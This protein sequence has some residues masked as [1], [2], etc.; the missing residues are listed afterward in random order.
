MKEL[1]KNSKPKPKK[2][3]RRKKGN[4]AINHES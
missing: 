2:E 3:I 1:E 4:K